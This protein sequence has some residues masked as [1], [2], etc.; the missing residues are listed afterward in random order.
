MRRLMLLAACPFLFSACASTPD[1]AEVCTTEW[2]KLRAEKA[3]TELLDD[4]QGAVKSM[5]KVTAKYVEGKTPG[6]LQLFALSNS[7]KSLEK[8]LTRGRGIRDLRTLAKTCNDPK[9]VMDGMSTFM[10]NLGLPDR[11]R[12]I[13]QAMPKYQELLAEQLQGLG[14]AN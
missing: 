14:K 2:I 13:V 6:P 1:P 7:L 10:D 8:E 11:L 12:A 5:R 3:V 4:T 9:I